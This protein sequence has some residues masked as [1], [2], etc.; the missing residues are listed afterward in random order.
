VNMCGIGNTM[1]VVDCEKKDGTTDTPPTTTTTAAPN[2]TGCVKEKEAVVCANVTTGGDLKKGVSEQECAEYCWSLPDCKAWSFYRFGSGYCY[3]YVSSDCIERNKGW[4]WDHVSWGSASCGAS[5]GCEINENTF[6][7][8]GNNEKIERMTSASPVME[9][10]KLCAGTA[11]CA[12][13]TLG[14]EKWCYIKTKATCKGSHTDW[15]S[16]TK[17]CG[18]V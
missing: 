11:S 13:W 12:G 4:F 5:K 15:I 6:L 9:C 2:P 10:S 3:P 17:E 1:V 16:G 18:Q 14:Y 8:A 7:C